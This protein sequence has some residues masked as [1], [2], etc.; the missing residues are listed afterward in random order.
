MGLHLEILWAQQEEGVQGRRRRGSG[1]VKKLR[2]KGE[3]EGSGTGQRDKNV[4]TE[5]EDLS[6][7]LAP[8]VCPGE[9]E[10]GSRIDG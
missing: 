6:D 3:G 4:P 10:G 2:K 5:M 9:Q 8:S 7:N 1:L